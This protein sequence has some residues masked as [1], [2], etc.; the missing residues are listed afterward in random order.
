M[1][2]FKKFILVKQPVLKLLNDNENL[3]N[4]WSFIAKELAISSDVDWEQA[5]VRNLLETL[6][7]LT[8]LDFGTHSVC[9]VQAFFWQYCC[10][11]PATARSKHLDG[12]KEFLFLY[13][14]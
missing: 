4:V 13:L 5:D 9:S 7:E 6:P 12:C 2:G 1:E 14:F 11:F 8:M 3:R 10:L